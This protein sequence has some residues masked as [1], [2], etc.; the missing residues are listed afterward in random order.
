MFDVRWMFGYLFCYNLLFIEP[1]RVYQPRKDS[2]SYCSFSEKCLFSFFPEIPVLRI[3]NPND[4]H[5][6]RRKLVSKS[7]RS[8]NSTNGLLSSNTLSVRFNRKLLKNC[9]C[10]DNFQERFLKAGDSGSGVF[11]CD[12]QGKPK[13]ALGIAF[14]FSNSQTLVCKIEDILEAFDI[15]YVK[16]PNYWKLYEDFRHIILAVTHVKSCQQNE[17]W[18]N[19][20]FRVLRKPK[21]NIL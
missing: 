5:C 7:R 15:P 8:A 4:I 6:D 17:F 2:S 11:L 10:I 13:G 20:D 12:T 14:G 1:R 3:I 9:Y 21:E 19:Y 16:V 18:K